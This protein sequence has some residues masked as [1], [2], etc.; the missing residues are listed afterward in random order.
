VEIAKAQAA[1]GRRRELY[2]FRDQQGLEVD[3]LMP[4][5]RGSLLLLEVKS[6][7][8]PTP[9]L[10]RSLERVARALTAADSRRAV[11]TLLVHRPPLH[12]SPAPSVAPGVPARPWDEF[13]LEL[14]H[15]R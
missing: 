15:H 2:Y 12:R 14:S 4:G 5:P 11:R 13:V 6:T 1:A 3:F 8:T 7:H 9:D 10:A